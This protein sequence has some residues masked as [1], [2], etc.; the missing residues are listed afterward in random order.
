MLLIPQLSGVDVEILN[1]NNNTTSIVGGNYKMGTLD[2]GTYNVVFSH[3]LYQSDT[4][5]SGCPAK[6]FNYCS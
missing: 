5:F 3:P 6:R 1:N 2:A 4:V